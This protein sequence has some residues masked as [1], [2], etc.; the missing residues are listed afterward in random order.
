M[1]TQTGAGGSATEARSTRSRGSTLHLQRWMTQLP[2][3]EEM[4]PPEP[5]MEVD[6]QLSTIIKDYSTLKNYLRLLRLP[7]L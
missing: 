7:T 3:A 5:E 4:D 6:H 2:E 1:E